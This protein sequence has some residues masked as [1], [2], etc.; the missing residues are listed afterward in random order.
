MRKAVFAVCA[1][2]SLALCLAFP[3]IFFM[4]KMSGENYKLFFLLSSLAW[5][6]FAFFWA[7]KRGKTNKNP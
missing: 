6:F 5:F 3:V 2:L 7:T 1:V 4:G